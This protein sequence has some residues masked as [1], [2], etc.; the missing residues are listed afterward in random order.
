MGKQYNQLTQENRIAISTLLRAGFSVSAISEQLG[1]HR[2]TLYREINRNS[3][4]ISGYLPI[5]AERL[6][7]ERKARSFK[8]NENKEL[9]H[10]VRECL[11]IGWSP[12]QIAGRLKQE[13]KGLPVISHETIYRWIYSD[14]GRRNK[15]YTLLRHK[16][17]WRRLRG[18]RKPRV[19]I[20]DRVSI[21]ERPMK[22]NQKEEFGHWEGD[23]ML[24][25]K[26]GTKSN[27]IT[28]RERVSRYFVAILNPS[29]HAIETA[30]RINHYFMTQGKSIVNSITFDNGSEFFAHLD[31]V[32][33]LGIST[34]FC[35]PYKSWQKGSVEN[36]NGVLRFELPRTTEIHKFT[37]K[38]INKTVMNINRRPMKC[39]G[40][41]TPEEV[42]NEHLLRLSGT[43]S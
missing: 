18:T 8:L 11:T 43:T 41:R 25:T 3:Q 5:V 33:Q 17:T 2:S 42:F 14:F 6:V 21:I 39:L 15:Y 16:R 22:I 36:G 34:Y 27:L 24:F 40:Y 26:A 12:E 30:A 29:R 38:E 37:Q 10:I 23:L 13:N 1:V 9:C 19:T 28:L 7:K 32:A 4:K 31:I 35:D 20:P